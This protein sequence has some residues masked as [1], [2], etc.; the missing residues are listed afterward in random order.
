MRFWKLF[1]SFHIFINNHKN[2]T[3]FSLFL[4]SKLLSFLYKH[5]KMRNKI[6]NYMTLKT[7]NKKPTMNLLLKLKIKNK[8]PT[9]N[10]LLKLKIAL[11]PFRETLLFTILLTL[12]LLYIA[13]RICRKMVSYPPRSKGLP[14]IG[15]MNIM[16][17]L[18]HRGL[19]KQCSGV[20]HHRM[21]FLHMVAISN[22]EAAHQVLQV[23]DNCHQLLNLQHGFRAPPP[24]VSLW[25]QQCCCR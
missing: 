21:G 22:A 1:F 8:K 15:N 4:F 3:P 12:L 18:T 7:G 14:L 13:S 11:E 10:L 2:T 16:E 19:A 6:K 9:M 23:R 5:L 25:V 17:Q 20:L 24:H